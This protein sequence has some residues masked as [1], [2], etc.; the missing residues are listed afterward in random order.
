MELSS[1]CSYINLAMIVIWLAIYKYVNPQDR[2]QYHC[3]RSDQKIN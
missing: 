1:P 2:I 3:V